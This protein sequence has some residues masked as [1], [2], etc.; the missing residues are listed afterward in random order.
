[1]V[2]TAPGSFY[3]RGGGHNVNNVKSVDLS[4]NE[5]IIPVSAMQMK[6]M[7]TE[8]HNNSLDLKT[9]LKKLQI[10]NL[11]YQQQP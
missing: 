10:Q 5:N 6:T 7:K 8:Q 11:S 2:I 3:G 4:N 1:M 9:Y